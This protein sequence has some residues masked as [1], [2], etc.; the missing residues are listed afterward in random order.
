MKI[1]RRDLYQR[2]W[3]TPIRTLARE[4]DISD[5]GLSKACRKHEIPTPPAGYWSKV[6][7]GKSVPRPALRGSSDEMVTLDAERHR[8]PAVAA[9]P[10]AAAVVVSVRDSAAETLAPIAAATFAVLSKAKPSETGFVNCGS[11]QLIH[12]SVSARTVRRAGEILDALERALPQVDAALVHDKEGKRVAIRVRGELL[13]LSLTEGYKRTETV[14]THPKHSYFNRR[15]YQYEFNGQLKLR[16]EGSY[17]GR[18]SWSD[19]ARGRLEN[20]LTDVVQ[21]VVAASEAVVRLRQEREAQARHWAEQR[22]IWEAAEKRRQQRKSFAEGLAKEA[23]AWQH[24]VDLARYLQ[25]LNE[26]IGHAEIPPEARAW[27]ALA[28][29]LVGEMNPIGRR[30][31][32]L[33]EPSDAG[34][35]YGPF[36]KPIV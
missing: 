24:H 20:K 11:T 27:L 6:Q 30:I 21:G 25:A 28:T 5:V 10:V 7:H 33:R 34:S 15:E 2:V 13:G 4:F 36:G 9:M 1:S 31:A 12:C 35:W 16:L 14:V 22:A 26:T 3:Q 29:E 32:V 18:K 17:A 19:G 23:Q 8:L